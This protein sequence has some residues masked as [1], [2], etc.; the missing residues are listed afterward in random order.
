MEATDN[1]PSEGSARNRPLAVVVLDLD[2]FKQAN[3]QHGHDAG[4]CWPR[5]ANCCDCACGWAKVAERVRVQVAGIEVL[6]NGDRVT[7]SAGVAARPQP[8]LGAA[9]A[10]G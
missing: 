4:R 7:I 9:A 10:G 6:P 5:P 1:R 2:H 8:P 3:D